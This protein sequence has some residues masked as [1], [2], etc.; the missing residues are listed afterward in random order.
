M[1]LDQRIS[2]EADSL[3]MLLR[4]AAEGDQA[5]LRALYQQ[6]APKLFGIILRILRNRSIAEEVLQE[7]FVRVW[8]NADRFTPEAGQ[9][10]AW[11]A[12]IARNKAI[13]RLRAEKFARQEVPEGSVMPQLAFESPDPVLRD[14]LRACLD[15]LDEEARECVVLAYCHGLSRE[16]LAERFGRPVGTIKTLIHRSMKLLRACLE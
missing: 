10:L 4:S 5:A 3:S 9:P 16:E 13:D 8:Q 14:S 2:R 1:P 7:T 12:T 11:L 15:E 6:T